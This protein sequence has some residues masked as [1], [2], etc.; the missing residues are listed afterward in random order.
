MKQRL[1]LANALLVPRELLVLDDPTNGL[2]P[3]G[4]REVRHLIR[5]LTGGGA[6]VFVSRH[7][8]AEI[9]QMC[10]HVAVM[11]LGGL[12]AQGTLDEL[13]RVGQA[14]IRL[15]TP[16]GASAMRVLARLGPES[17]AA[18]EPDVGFFVT[19]ALSSGADAA[20]AGPHR[21]RRVTGRADSPSRRP[22]SRRSSTRACG[23]AAS[24]CSRQ[25]SRSG[26]S[27]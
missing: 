18:P 1:G 8:L 4:T 7:L 26:S 22:S 16:D 10:T 19:A 23:C 2:D 27:R 6:T 5:T 11:S 15:L 9:E 21:P 24:P 25:A 12:V 20:V 3:Q 14:H 17:G 13:R